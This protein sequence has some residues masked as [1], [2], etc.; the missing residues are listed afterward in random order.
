MKLWLKR[1]GQSLVPYDDDGVH[2]FETLP[3]AT[4]L[5][6]MVNQP[7]NAKRLALY[8]SIVGRVARAIGRPTEALDRYLRVASGHCDIFHTQ[9]YG[10]VR[11]PKPINFE[12]C[13]DETEF[14]A[15]FDAALIVIHSELGIEPE[16]LAD[17]IE[18]KNRL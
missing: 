18:R 10:E 14:M 7:R 9:K 12:E 4:P 15:F 16:A 11:I 13:Q 5:R 6:G 2:D 17:L 1:Y 3:P 8:W